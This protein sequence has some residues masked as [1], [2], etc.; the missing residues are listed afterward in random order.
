MEKEYYIVVDDNRVGPLTLAQ[1]SE[2]GIEPSTLVWTAGMADW[3]RADS[4]PE[5]APLFAN[6]TRIDENESAFGSYARPVEPAATQYSQQQYGAYN[7]PNQG[8]GSAN[9]SAN[10]KT[11]AIVATVI[12]F[13][14]SCIGGIVGCFAISNAS[15]AE[16]AMRY[17]DNF[18]AQSAWSTCKTLCIVSFVLSGLGLIINILQILKFFSVA[19]LINY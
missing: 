15:K 2:R 12:G 9:P 7:N 4:V 14:F 13:L 5:L 17:G 10:W 8:P 18:T 1:L 19:S 11:I 6:R 16:N 3:S